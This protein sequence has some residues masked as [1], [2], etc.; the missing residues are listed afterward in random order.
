MVKK[1]TV[2]SQKPS[3][4]KKGMYITTLN[5]GFGEL[6]AYAARQLQP[7]ETI[8]VSIRQ[9]AMTDPLA[10]TILNKKQTE[11][12]LAQNDKKED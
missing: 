8:V 5:D 11:A 6:K 2:V 1:A 9:G 10:V 4:A 3:M 12:W 7:G